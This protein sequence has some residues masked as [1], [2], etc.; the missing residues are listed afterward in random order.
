MLV[1]VKLFATF[2]QKR[3]DKK[4]MD[5]PATSSVAFVLEQL[6]IPAEL[7]GILLINGQSCS[8]ETELS[9]DDVVSIFPAIGGG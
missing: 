8:V 4:V 7:V 6:K 3:F 9:E 2:R 1:E 5:L